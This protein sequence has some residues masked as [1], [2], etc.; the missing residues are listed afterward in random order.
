MTTV[1][2][3][4]IIG[5]EVSRERGRSLGASKTSGEVPNKIVT[6]GSIFS[7]ILRA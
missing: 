5:L 6:L 1:E 4:N 3:I 7:I 2:S